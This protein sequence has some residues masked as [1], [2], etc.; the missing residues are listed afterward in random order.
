MK[1][2]LI[3]RNNDAE[4]RALEEVCTRLAG[5]N[6]NLSYEWVDGFLTGLAAGPRLP[7]AAAWIEALAGDAFT[8]LFADPNDQGSAT[9]A[10]QARLHVLCKQLDPEA[11]FNDQDTLR[12]EP[13]MEEWDDA[14]RQRLKDTGAMSEEDLAMV[15]SG[16]A[17]AVA[18]FAAQEAF[19]ELHAVPEDAEA[20][21]L[22]DRAFQQLA[23][24]TSPVG[25]SEYLAH[26]RQFYG[27]DTPDRDELIAQALWSVQDMR[28][29]WVDFA[30]KPT[31]VRVDS[32]P[33][34]NDPCHCGSGKKFKKCHGA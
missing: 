32:K 27:A 16:A 31:T 6:A 29:F 25:S 23:V 22:F 3:P 10:L 21:E 12:L 19:P 28:M 2:L 20:T 33:G 9:S 18:F 4:M 24:L 8:R 30:P 7:D 15:N 1:H 34:R 13:L 5:F 26:V 17:W 14:A 11:L